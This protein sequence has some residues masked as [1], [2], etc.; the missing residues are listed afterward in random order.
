MKKLR[1][2]AALLLGV[3]ALTAIGAVSASAAPSSALTC[4]GGPITTNTYSSITV[5]GACYVPDGAN[6][7]VLH[8]LTILAGASFDAQTNSAV[9]IYGN[10]VAGPGSQFGLGCTEA[11]PCEGS[12]P[13]SGSTNDFVAG[14]VILNEVYNAAINGDHIGRNLISTGGGARTT[15]DGFVPFSVK[16][17]TIDGNVVV[18][19][20]QTVWFGIIRST[21]GGNVV[22]TNN[23]ESGDPDA[24]EVV[25]NTIGRNLICHGNS[26]TPQLGDAVEGAPPGYGPN[27]VGGHAIGQC[28]ELSS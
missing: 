18:S 20:L 12:Q 13:E 14:N 26:P 5:T 27:T 7:T 11:H 4:S 10:V 23:V 3:G 6:V 25:A 9:T 19:G 16:D 28:A 1:K 2:G 24:N 22:L 21:I 8:N 15:A 17:D